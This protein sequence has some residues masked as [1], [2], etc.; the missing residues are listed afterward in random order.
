MMMTD[1][2]KTQIVVAQEELAQIEE[3]LAYFE[4]IREFYPNTDEMTDRQL[5]C[6]FLVRVYVNPRSFS[7]ADSHLTRKRKLLSL[8]KSGLEKKWL[9]NIRMS[10]TTT[11]SSDVR[12]L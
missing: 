1:F 10:N 2:I 3:D 9:P 8:P 7:T 6:I 5:S 4:A 12:R 11:T